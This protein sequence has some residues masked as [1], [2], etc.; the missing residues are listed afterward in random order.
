M[1]EYFTCFFFKSCDDGKVILQLQLVQI[2]FNQLS[3]SCSKC[4][5]IED[6]PGFKVGMGCLS[7][8]LLGYYTNKK[9]GD[10]R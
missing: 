7:G 9:I 10:G 3:R 4:P 2:V 6:C 5:L 8:L 1:S